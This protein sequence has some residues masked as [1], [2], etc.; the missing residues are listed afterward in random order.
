V[1]PV[2]IPVKSRV[3]SPKY[4]LFIDAKNISSVELDIEIFFVIFVEFQHKSLINKSTLYFH[5]SKKTILSKY[6][7][8]WIVSI[9]FDKLLITH[10]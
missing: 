6:L 10:L 4:S 7:P 2:I 3:N 1:L 9:F 8:V 5:E